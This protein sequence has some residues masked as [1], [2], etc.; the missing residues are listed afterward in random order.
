MTLGDYLGNDGHRRPPGWC[1]VAQPGRWAE[2]SSTSG[3]SSRRCSVRTALAWPDLHAMVRWQ[4]WQRMT[5]RRLTATGK[6]RELELLTALDP[7]SPRGAGR[8][9]VAV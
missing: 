5:G 2:A 7:A 1:E 6:R 9:R 4:T 3:C 8:F